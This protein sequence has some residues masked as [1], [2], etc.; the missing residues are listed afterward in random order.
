M[1]D[2]FGLSL[3]ADKQAA[4]DAAWAKGKRD[5]RLGVDP[6]AKGKEKA[7]A[8]PPFKVDKVVKEGLLK[9]RPPTEKELEAEVKKKAGLIRIYNAYYQREETRPYLPKQV[10]L[11][12][13]MPLSAIQGALYGVRQA[14]NS[15]NSA[16]TIRRM[17]PTLVE[18]IIT[19]L[20]AAGLLEQMGLEGAEGAGN[21]LKLAMNTPMM[22]T[23]LTEMEI[24]LEDLFSASWYTRILVKTWL[25]V[26]AYAEENKNRTRAAPPLSPAAAAAMGVAQA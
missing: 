2:P 25:F 12:P 6:T 1:S 19:A 7:D 16:E 13:S 17:Y 21:A 14:M 26:K 18:L 9:P 23:E 22:Q 3:T 10:Q 11:T 5:Q 15:A 4:I 24:E 8:P 20:K